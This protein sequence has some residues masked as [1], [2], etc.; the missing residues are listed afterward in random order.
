MLIVGNSELFAN[1]FVLEAGAKKL[2]EFSHQTAFG[3]ERRNSE[4][5]I[6]SS[7]TRFA[8]KLVRKVEFSGHS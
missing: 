5:S 8:S 6:V 7:S 2:L 3:V 1:R 4:S